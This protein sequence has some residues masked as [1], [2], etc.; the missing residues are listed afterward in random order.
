MFATSDYLYAG[1]GNIRYGCQ[2]WKTDAV[3]RPPYRWTKIFDHSA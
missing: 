3:G 2:L 1:T